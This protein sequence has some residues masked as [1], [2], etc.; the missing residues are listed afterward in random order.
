MGPALLD[1]DAAV[2]LSHG[3][4]NRVE[5]ERAQGARVDYLG[6]H[7]VLA[8]ELLSGAF[9]CQRHPRDTDD[10]DVIARLRNPRTAEWQRLL[11]LLVDLAAHAIQRLVLDEDDRVLVADS[12]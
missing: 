3:M 7:T 6:L 10:R 8:C 2:G 4:Q 11:V 9:C 5:V 1:D 12:G